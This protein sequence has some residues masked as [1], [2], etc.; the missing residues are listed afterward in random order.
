MVIS[1]FFCYHPC[2]L[3]ILRDIVC[4]PIHSFLRLASIIFITVV[5]FSYTLPCLWCAVFGWAC[6]FL[7]HHFTPCFYS[8]WSVSCSPFCPLGAYF[9]PSFLSALGLRWVWSGLYGSRP[10]LHSLLP[11]G[12]VCDVCIYSIEF[13]LHLMVL[14]HTKLTTPP[15]RPSLPDLT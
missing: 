2:F 14:L 7:G 3:N 9:A 12:S 10:S 13:S 4:Y 11:L 8:V 15:G 1:Y 5:L 6:D